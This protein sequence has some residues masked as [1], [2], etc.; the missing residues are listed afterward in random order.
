MEWLTALEYFAW[1]IFH[2]NFKRPVRLR[3]SEYATEMCGVM[4]DIERGNGQVKKY[5]GA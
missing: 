3:Y 1:W 2:I 5:I 4:S